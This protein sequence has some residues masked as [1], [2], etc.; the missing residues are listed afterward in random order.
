MPDPCPIILRLSVTELWIT[1]YDHISVIENSHC[2]SAMSRELSPGWQ[3]W[4]TF[5]KTPYPN[6]PIYPLHLRN[7]LHCV[8]AQKYY[9]SSA[10]VFMKSKKSVLFNVK[11]CTWI[12]H[13][14]S[15][16]GRHTTG[17]FALDHT[18]GQKSPRPPGSAPFTQFLIHPCEPLHCEILGCRRWNPSQLPSHNTLGCGSYRHTGVMWSHVTPYW[19][20]FVMLS[21]H[22]TLIISS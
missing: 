1:E 14:A 5:S 8:F 19:I 10:P 2:T 16:S 11:N 6:L 18:R 12:S 22:N 4:S 17:G 7:F 15:A 21:V 20:L 13:F 9:P 3:K